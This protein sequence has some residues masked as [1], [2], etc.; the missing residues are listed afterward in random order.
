VFEIGNAPAVAAPCY[1][2]Q[3]RLANDWGVEKKN[4]KFSF[5]NLNMNTLSLLTASLSNAENT[6]V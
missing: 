2:E 6:I 3:Y 1:L 5:K 4:F